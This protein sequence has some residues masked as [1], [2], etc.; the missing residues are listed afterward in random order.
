MVSKTKKFF[1]PVNDLQIHLRRDKFY[2]LRRGT[3]SIGSREKLWVILLIIWLTRKWKPHV[4]NRQ[5]I[6]VTADF[7]GGNKILLFVVHS[8]SRADRYF[9]VHNLIHWGCE[10]WDVSASDEKIGIVVRTTWY[11]LC[12][13]RYILIV[14]RRQKICLLSSP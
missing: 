9:G 2:S 4:V 1:L 7:K 5:N 8:I 10:L 14:L 12:H 3:V 11:L 13:R 6:T